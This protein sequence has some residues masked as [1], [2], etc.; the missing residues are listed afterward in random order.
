M[1]NVIPISQL[2]D[3]SLPLSGNESFVVV[4]DNVTLKVG[5][6]ALGGGLGT[7]YGACSRSGGSKV[8]AGINN[9]MNGVEDGTTIIGGSCNKI[10]ID[11]SDTCGI[12]GSS[13][14]VSGCCNTLSGLALDNSAI[15]TGKNNLINTI[16]PAGWLLPPEG[17]FI[18]GGINNS[19]Y[20]TI[21]E[22][23]FIGAGCCNNTGCRR[24]AVVAGCGNAVY[25][26]DDGGI[27]AGRNNLVSDSCSVIAGGESNSI[28][29]T[30]NFIGGGESNYVDGSRSSIVAGF[31]NEV[32]GGNSTIGGGANNTLS[33]NSAFIGGGVFNFGGGGVSFIGGGQFNMTERTGSAIVAGC[34]NKTYDGAFFSV[35]GGGRCNNTRMCDSF[36]GA[37]CCNLT[38]Q[39]SYG[40]ARSFIGGGLCNTVSGSDSFIGGGYCN[41]TQSNASAIIGGAQNCICNTHEKAFIVGSNITSV[42]SNMLHATTLYLSAA[43]L[44]T[45]DPGVA[46]VV[47]N[48][49]GT[50]KISV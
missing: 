47:W 8:L 40:F 26:G 29:G 14:I 46:G 10:S 43:A 18:G 44:P 1:S 41:I 20:S 27:V 5:S 45:S 37:G 39:P 49:S 2:E 31:N 48:D 4:Q 24:N 35:I 16:A 21:P 17:N 22:H 9:Y 7:S 36:I 15:V 38:L 12:F 19:I 23:N 11:V 30:E 25:G 33:G 32:N 13:T 34:K 6:S 3:A 28:A 42:S 50:L